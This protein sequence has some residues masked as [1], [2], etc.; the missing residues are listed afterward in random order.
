MLKIETVNRDVVQI[1]VTVLFDE[2]IVAL[3]FPGGAMG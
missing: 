2:E 3:R 1:D